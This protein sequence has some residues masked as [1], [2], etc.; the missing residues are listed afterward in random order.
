MPFCYATEAVSPKLVASL[1]LFFSSHFTFFTPLPLHFHSFC[2][3]TAGMQIVKK[4]EFS[5]FSLHFH[6]THSW[7][8][9]LDYMEETFPQSIVT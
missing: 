4:S 2:S 6:S 3:K 7:N 1:F 5:L 9:P 8:W